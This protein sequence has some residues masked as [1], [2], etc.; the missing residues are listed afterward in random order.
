MSI[1]TEQV[2]F[3]LER[4]KANLEMLADKLQAAQDYNAEFP[5]S[6]AERLGEAIKIVRQRDQLLEFA[7][8]IL[9]HWPDGADLD[10]GD[11]QEIAVKRGLLIGRTVNEP[12]H[13]GDPD[14]PC[15]CSV[16]C[17][18]VDFANGVTCYSRAE[19]LIGGAA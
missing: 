8:D 16:Y 7:R 13:G 6:D 1:N 3:S 11:I 12:C 18:N 15:A 4:A 9:Q 19:F 10:G 17:D 2:I 5:A 14:K